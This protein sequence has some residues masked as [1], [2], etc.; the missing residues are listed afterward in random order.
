[1]F[2]IV[3]NSLL[4]MAGLNV[5]E[6]FDAMDNMSLKE[7]DRIKK[8]IE[9]VINKKKPADRK[10]IGSLD[11]ND[12]VSLYPNFLSEKEINNISSDLE[13]FKKFDYRGN[14]TKSVW[15]S[16][17][18]LPY[19]WTSHSSGINTVKE[20]NPMS[21]YEHIQSLLKKINASMGTN[22]NSCLIQYYPNGSSG[23]RIHDDFEWEMDQSQPFVNVSIGSCRKIEF[24]HNYQKASETPAK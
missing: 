16:T 10:F 6:F 18:S 8:H 12:Y 11:V 4:S 15:L 17:T 2:A 21:D 9:R 23:I 14:T 19:K 7:L 24:F 22:L 1:M 5:S 20:A 3:L 13:S